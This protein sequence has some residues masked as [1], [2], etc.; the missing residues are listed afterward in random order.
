MITTTSK[1]TLSIITSTL[2]EVDNIDKTMESLFP[3][4]PD[5][6]W[7]YVDGGSQD[8]TV[9]KASKYAEFVHFYP[10]CSLYE[11]FNNGIRHASGKYIYYLNAGDTIISKDTLQR[12]VEVLKN[13]DADLYYF[14][15]L[16]PDGHL[17]PMHRD[18]I[19]YKMPFSHQG[20]VM[21]RT[22]VDRIGW[23]DDRCGPAADHDLIVRMWLQE[24]EFE[25]IKNLCLTRCADWKSTEDNL[26]RA[27]NRWRNVRNQIKKHF[28]HDLSKID[29]GYYDIVSFAMSS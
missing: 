7:V 27:L 26:G 29:A 6:E 14:N 20:C 9:A 25:E 5:V 23:F 1:F 22:T 17:F 3:L 10:G 28:P 21:K 15:T 24:C 11:G 8:G 12:L 2:N 13:G 18:K 16:M 4:L 19:F